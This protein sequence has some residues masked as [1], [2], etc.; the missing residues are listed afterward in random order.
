MADNVAITAG[1]GTTVAADDVGGVLH[2]RVKVSIGAD[3]TAADWPVG[4]GSQAAVPRVTLATD[5]PGVTALGQATM[6]AS[7]PVTLASNQSAVS[8]TEIDSLA[9][10]G[11]V[12]SA[13]TLF[14]QDMTGYESITVQVTSAGTSCTITYETSD[15]NTNWLSIAGWN[16]ANVTSGFY[17]VTSTTAIMMRFPRAGKFFRARVSTYGS[18]TVTVVGNAHKAPFTGNTAVGVYTSFSSL[19]VI[20]PAAA[21]SVNNSPIPI[22]LNARSTNPA[23]VDSADVVYPLATLLGA[24]V[25]KPYSIPETDWS[26]AAATAGIANTTTA[27]TIAAAAGA[28]LRNYIT[29]IQLMSEALGAASEFAIRDGAG[30]TVIWRTKIG[31]G[32]VTAGESITF[33]SPLKSTANTLLEVVTL[34]ASVTGAVFFNAQGYIAP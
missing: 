1:S 4:S 15:D 30:G 17:S 25:S 10:S 16:P 28:G 18:G 32:G 26:Y 21:G 14:T 12:T 6:A 5:S 34:T 11:S 24:Q 13:T 20:G 31:T 7:L 27:V 9:V 2:Q 8:T 3:G 22:G 23:V 19:S 33:P 29:S